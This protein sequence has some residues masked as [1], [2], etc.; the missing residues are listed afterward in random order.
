[1]WSFINNKNATNHVRK[2]T[3][4]NIKDKNKYDI[5]PFSKRRNV[6]RN[7]SSPYSI[8]NMKKLARNY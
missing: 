1:V 7:V 4:D 5:D 8:V 6:L 3:L 2:L